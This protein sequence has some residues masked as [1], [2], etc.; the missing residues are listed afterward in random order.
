M[1]ALFAPTAPESS[2]PNYRR[3][4]VSGAWYFFT[5]VTYDRRPILTTQSGL[6]ALKSAIVETRIR[7]PFTSIA[8]VILPN[9]LHYIWK[10]P[11]GDADFS[12]RWSIIKWR[13]TREFLRG[14]DATSGERSVSRKRHRERNVW[15]RRFW[16]HCIQDDE[17]LRRH[18]DYIHYNPVK[19][20]LVE[21]LLQWRFSSAHRPEYMESYL[22]AKSE[23]AKIEVVGAE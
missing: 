21:E 3:V 7:R 13:F 17:D 11:D 2:M 23:L 20:G 14:T 19:H 22:N 4:Y 10:L 5:V 18:I 12:T 8:W 15:Q 1:G 9:H 6:A 16:E